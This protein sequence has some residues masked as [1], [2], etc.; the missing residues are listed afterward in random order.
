MK[1]MYPV[2]PTMTT[3]ATTFLNL[4]FANQIKEA[5]SEYSNE[6]EYTTEG[7][8][9]RINPPA[10]PRC[11]KQMCHNGSNISAILDLASIK[12]GRYL[13]KKCNIS[14]QEK[15]TF[16]LKMKSEIGRILTGL[17]QVLRNHSVSFEG[18]S[19]VMDYIIPKSGD[20]ICR[21]FSD[22]VAGVQ[23][24]DDSSIQI[25]HY[26]EQYPKAGRSQ[27]YRLTLLNGVSH[28]VIAEE[29]FDNKTQ[30]AIKLF[31]RKNLE[32]V[33]EKSTP[34]FIVTDLGKGYAEL[35]TEVF[36]GNAIH[37]YCLFHLNQL[38]AK[39]FSKNAP[40]KDELVKYMLFNIFYDREVELNYLR[41]VVEEEAS[42]DFKDEK[43]E[44]E[45]RKSAKIRFYGFLHEQELKRRR[46]HKN[47]RL[48]T[49]YESH[50]IFNSL[51]DN[52]NS[53]SLI[54]QKRLEKI[55]KGWIHFTA[56]Q[57]VEDAPATNNAIENYYSTSLK[58]QK[59]KQLRTDRGIKTHMKLSS[60]K[61]LNMIGKPEIT[62]LEA[63]LK[64]NPFRAA[65]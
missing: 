37:Q 28:N 48:R 4:P 49:Y 40:M 19:E 8:F 54:V 64:I 34:I 5:F 24:P 1:Y 53:F 63:I 22:S 36:N 52:A 44:K 42:I 18:M 58:G 45:W 43:E 12:L 30:E 57:R 59:K 51:L 13:C 33:I 7:V 39:E 38:I 47:L 29:L 15:N 17:Y 35:I 11:G 41:E 31:F 61:R 62:F 56:F 60:M 25:V 55:Q 10:C 27:K 6:Y 26:D 65:G 14:V 16:W 3:I 50:V 20:T 9:R 21:N 2:I 46:D 32:Y 23:I